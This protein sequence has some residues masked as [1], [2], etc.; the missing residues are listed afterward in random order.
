MSLEAAV[1]LLLKNKFDVDDRTPEFYF[2]I[3]NV[4]VFGFVNLEPMFWV[5]SFSL[6][7]LQSVFNIIAAT[8]MYICIV[9]RQQ[10]KSTQTYLLGYGVIIPLL[11]WLPFHI[12][13]KVVEFHNVALLLCLT[14]GSAALLSFRCLEAMHGTLPP[15]A[16]ESFVKFIMYNAT[17]V[18]FNFDP[19]TH[20]AIPFTVK[21]FIQRSAV[22][23]GL[24]VQATICYSFLLPT[25]YNLFPRRI[26]ISS[27]S[28]LF[29]W[30]NLLHNLV[31]ASFT[32]IFLDA[33]CTG[34][35][36]LTSLLTGYSTMSFNDNPLTQS[37]SVSDFW[38]KRWD[39]IVGVALRRGIFR[40]LRQAGVSASL[41]AFGTF[42]VSALLHE[43][44]LFVMAMRGGL[45]LQDKPYQPTVGKQSLFFLWNG[46]CLVAEHLLADHPVIVWMR[47]TLP[48]PVRTFL[49][50]AMVMPVVH[51]FTDE[52]VASSFY[53]D[54]A[55][56]FPKV[57]YVYV[58]AD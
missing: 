25:N 26:P 22:F 12:A 30:G 48:R 40:P 4:G 35:G 32:S 20:N 18:Q 9:R 27:I 56:G 34:L 51:L 54:G 33:G 58:G 55:F 45:A 16:E 46:V 41:A 43:Y 28:D 1:S 50:I 39:K 52:Y 36:I 47:K 53:S 14:G 31:M 7:M 15:L 24:F 11:L 19:K 29:Y 8:I 3:P 44:M 23:L 49:V 10:K 5:Q 2:S 6:L 42:A 38:G 21:E 57:V 17:T 37:T 13:A